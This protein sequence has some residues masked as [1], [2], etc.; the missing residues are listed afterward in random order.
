MA[1]RT[2]V[3]GSIRRKMALFIFG[4]CLV[5]PLLHIV[6]VNSMRISSWRLF[7]WGM[8]ASPNPDQQARLRVIILNQPIKNDD[9]IRKLHGALQQLHMEPSQESFC[10]NLFSE[11]GGALKKLPKQALCRE[12]ELATHFDYFLHFGSPRHLGK[13]VGEALARSERVGSEAL[14]FLTHQ[15]FSLFE[16]KAYLES[17]VYRVIGEEA[18]YVGK[19]KTEG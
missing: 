12:D 10:L 15:R 9:D 11:V 17:E 2:I 16:G 1:L 19:V 14:A 5:W 4:L 6:L 8:Y 7:G 3:K 18:V 13:F